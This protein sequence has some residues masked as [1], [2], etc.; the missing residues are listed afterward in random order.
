MQRQIV[1]QQDLQIRD[2]TVDDGGSVL[3]F[4]V[5]D[6]HN[7]VGSPHTW[8][9]IGPF[10][11]CIVRS[12]DGSEAHPLFQSLLGSRV[13]ITIERLADTPPALDVGP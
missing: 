12:V 2:F 4:G 11:A 6:L 10:L 9:S 1:F 3:S 13:R 5:D 8:Q 7:G